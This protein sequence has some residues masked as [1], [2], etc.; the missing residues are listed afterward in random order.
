MKSLEPYR[1]F[2]RLVITIVAAIFVVGGTFGLHI[3]HGNPFGGNVPTD[4]FTF[5]LG[6]A[7]LLLQRIFG[8]K[9]P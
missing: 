6:L 5:S 3:P 4:W 2:I 8:R 9:K 7:I 1:N